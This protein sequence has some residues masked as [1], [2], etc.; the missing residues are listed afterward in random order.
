MSKPS[1]PWLRALVVAWSLLP[2]AAPAG[3]PVIESV[4]GPSSLRPGESAVVSV[5]ARDPDDGP[6][7]YAW[8][9]SAGELV[10]DGSSATLVALATEGEVRVTVTVTSASGERGTSFIAISVAA[11][12]DTPD[13][14]PAP[15][16]PPAA[17]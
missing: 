2:R 6:L 14:V 15:S 9:A 7:T 4:T 16:P 8:A 12:V 11:P 13:A 10:A 17:P 1:N 3:E 5:Q